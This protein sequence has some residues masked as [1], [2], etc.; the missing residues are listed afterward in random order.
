MTV[1][2]ACAPGVGAAYLRVEVRSADG[3]FWVDPDDIDRYVCDV[4]RF[5]CSGEGGRVTARFC[6]CAP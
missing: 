3:P 6:Q 5:V 4:G 1:I 2:S